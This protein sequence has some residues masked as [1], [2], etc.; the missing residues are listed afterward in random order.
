MLDKVNRPITRPF[1]K[2]FDRILLAVGETILGI[3]QQELGQDFVDEINRYV[4]SLE[5]YL[6]KD[7]KTLVTLFNSRISVFMKI[8][9]F[10]PFHTLP[11]DEREQYLDTWKTSTIP[12]FRTGYVALR[13]LAGWAYYSSEKGAEEMGSYGKTIGKEKETPTLLSKT[14]YPESPLAGEEKT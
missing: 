14:F 6:R 2:S 8:L 1:P 3:P 5:P 4:G 10:K 7:I 13:S 9:T 12:L 11:L